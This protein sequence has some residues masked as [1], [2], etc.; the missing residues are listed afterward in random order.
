MPVK[1]RIDDWLKD[2]RW[3]NLKLKS[4]RRGKKTKRYVSESMPV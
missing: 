4:S 1:E 2:E 3:K